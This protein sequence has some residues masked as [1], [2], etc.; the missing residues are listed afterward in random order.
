MSLLKLGQVYVNLDSVA[1]IR[2][3]STRDSTGLVV[4]GMFRLEFSGGRSIEIAADAET[5]R[6]WI[7]GN[8][9]PLPPIGP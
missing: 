7:N 9:T 1:Y 5:L 6:T 2:D 3:I 8:L 4:Q